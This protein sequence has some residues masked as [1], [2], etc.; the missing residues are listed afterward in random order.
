MLLQTHFRD[1]VHLP[2]T[3][4]TLSEVMLTFTASSNNAA[5]IFGSINVKL[6]QLRFA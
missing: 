4:N 1:E 6:T 5:A 2:Q 3:H